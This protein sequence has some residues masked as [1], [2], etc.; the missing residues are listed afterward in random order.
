M[1]FTEP[2]DN[3]PMKESLNVYI[4][5]YMLFMY[6]TE[7]E[8]IQAMDILTIMGYFTL[9]TKM[10]QTIRVYARIKAIQ[11]IKLIAGRL[12]SA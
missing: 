8:S 7:S 3:R 5:E 1:T 11:K 9:D 10:Q 12:E 6:G 4:E 2:F